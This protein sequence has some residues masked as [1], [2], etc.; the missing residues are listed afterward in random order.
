MP[1]ET[2]RPGRAAAVSSGGG[3]GE[4]FRARSGSTTFRSHEGSQVVAKS[5]Y[6][7]S[8]SDEQCASVDVVDV[9]D[10]TTVDNECT[11]FRQRAYLNWKLLSDV[12][13]SDPQQ[14][15][16]CFKNSVTG[17]PST[18]CTDLV[19]Y[20][21]CSTQLGCQAVC[22]SSG[23]C[24]WRTDDFA[25]NAAG[26]QAHPT[27]AA[28]CRN[29]L[30]EQE[31]KA[32]VGYVNSQAWCGTTD[33]CVGNWCATDCL[34]D[35]FAYCGYRM[36]RDGGSSCVDD[37][38]CRAVCEDDNA[39]YEN[40]DY[41]KCT[42]KNDNPVPTMQFVP[43]LPSTCVNPADRIGGNPNECTIF[44][45]RAYLN[46]KL[47][48][49][50]RSSDPQQAKACFANPVSSPPVASPVFAP[51][52]SPVCTEVVENSGCATRHSCEEACNQLSECAWRTDSAHVSTNYPIDA[53]DCSTYLEEQEHAARTG[54]DNAHAHC[55]TSTP[56][57]GNWCGTA[58]LADALAYC[59]YR[60]IADN[61]A[62]CVDS[63]SCQAVCEGKN[64]FY[65]GSDDGR[66]AAWYKCTWIDPYPLATPSSEV[67]Q[68]SILGSTGDTRVAETTPPEKRQRR[69]AAASTSGAG[70]G[71]MSR[72]KSGS[73]TVQSH[74]EGSQVVAKS[75]CTPSVFPSDEQ[76]SIFRQRAY[77]NWKL[78]YDVR[79]SDPQ[80]AKAC[81]NKADLGLGLT[82]II[83]TA[84]TEPTPSTECTDMV[85]DHGCAT[86][87]ACQA[88][89]ESN[90][91]C[92]WRT[93]SVS[94]SSYPA[95]SS[96]CRD[97]LKEQEQKAR[98]GY[99]N[100]K[101]WCGTTDPCVGNWCATDCLT[102]AFAYCGYRMIAD[103]GTSCV[104]TVTCR[105]VCED[106]NAFYEN[107]AW[108]KCT[109]KDDSPLTSTTM[110]TPPAVVP[111]CP[112]QPP[113]DECTIFKQ[114]AYLNSKLLYDIRESRP[115]KA[116][117][118]FSSS[119]DSSSR[120]LASAVCTDKV[121]NSGCENR[122]D[123]QD[124]CQSLTACAWRDDFA[125]VPSTNY[126]IDTSD[127]RTYLKSEELAGRTGYDNPHAHC[128]TTTPCTGN[129]CSDHCLTDILALAQVHL[130]RFLPTAADFDD[131]DIDDGDIDA[132]A[133]DSDD[134]G[135]GTGFDGG[136]SIEH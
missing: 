40:A 67:E 84:M 61:G 46:W 101:A 96:D 135:T 78:L 82:T 103:A 98:V 37:A 6:T 87:Y 90:V 118:C 3:Y 24:A 76:C 33:P 1:P 26:F 15:M 77:L 42:W 97:Y 71:E 70:S 128:A 83:N 117:A 92:A 16:A 5:A 58:C 54:Y 105:A 41:Y 104:D 88:V 25:A 123:C 7:V 113:G 72:A 133:D 89:C 116:K 32:R 131:G 47:L 102:D 111:S 52:A 65:A 120:P 19:E 63:A 60:M 74:A 124:E 29:Y 99:V 127:C 108:Y 86:P 53:S 109:W 59:S 30:K 17:L 79:A 43:V 129:W 112:V 14:H 130:D 132:G 2:R 126:P 64:A 27:N 110:L 28:G 69:A 4:M 50:I 34:I 115:Q 125:Q 95:V 119:V 38:S 100:D 107:A 73:T 35:A 12:R 114:R 44:R 93:D 81:F 62:S 18:E 49:D 13:T 9:D 45:Q 66:N 36:I 48:Y 106:A 11:I 8:R 56:C 20:H 57:T 51:V 91:N 85:L 134:A 94:T 68:V 10:K 31:Q 122:G 23:N 80:Q 22:E 21:G 121:V 39:F 75:A 55:A 136:A